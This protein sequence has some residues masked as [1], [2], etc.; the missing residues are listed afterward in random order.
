MNYHEKKTLLTSVVGLIV[1]L[2]YII[3]A[4]NVYY[5]GTVESLAL[6]FWATKIL[7][8]VGV[9]VISIVIAL[10]I[11]HILYSIY[12]SIKLKTE[13]KDMTDNEIEEIVSQMIE[14]DTFED[15]MA[16]LIGLKAMRIG[17]AFAGVGF[18]LSLI[19][20]L[21]NYS[22]IIMINILYLSF[23]LGAVVEGFVQVYYF[24]KGINHV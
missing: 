15:E 10:V 12:L 7:I 18:V 13:N 19:S 9:G 8:F 11:F 2:S 1:L 4:I 21:L 3:Y 5:E 20:L 16:K 23:G 6:K 24:R 17:F 14:T 22:P